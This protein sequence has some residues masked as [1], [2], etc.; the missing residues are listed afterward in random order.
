MVRNTRME[1]R[2][3]YDSALMHLQEAMKNLGWIY[4][5]YEPY[6]KEIADGYMTFIV[7]IKV[8]KDELE[9]YFKKVMTL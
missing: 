4:D 8:I 6:H 9:Q 3:H 7:S 1:I 5:K 2:R